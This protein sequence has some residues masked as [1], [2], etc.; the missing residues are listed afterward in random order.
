MSAC[1][2]P[3]SVTGSGKSDAAAPHLSVAHACGDLEPASLAQIPLSETGDRT[4]LRA[5][6]GTGVGRDGG[7][8]T[9]W[10]EK[11]LLRCGHLS[12]MLLTKDDRKKKIQSHS[13]PTM[14][15]PKVGTSEFSGKKI[16]DQKKE[17]NPPKLNHICSKTYSWKTKGYRLFKPF[18]Y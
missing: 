6:P 11:H 16:G 5:P 12:A 3:H 1:L 9:L 2:H 13:S 10:L 14:A 15:T 17:K 4:P 18:L 8:Q 7:V